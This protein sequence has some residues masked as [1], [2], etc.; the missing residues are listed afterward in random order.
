[1]QLTEIVILEIDQETIK[2][3]KLDHLQIY[4]RYLVEISIASSKEVRLCIFIDPLTE[5]QLTIKFLEENE[6]IEEVKGLELII[7]KTDWDDTDDESREEA[8]EEEDDKT[9]TQ[10]YGNKIEPLLTA[11]TG[12]ESL[13]IT[14]QNHYEGDLFEPTFSN[15]S[16]KKLYFD[17]TIIR[18]KDFP[19]ICAIFENLEE[20]ELEAE[21]FYSCNLNLTSL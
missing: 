5:P 2:E 9:D 4:S 3:D 19:S 15:V 21:N 6:F 16:C 12:L 18:Q 11:L 10:C 8:E 20:I 13:R 14:R 7:G 1:V 17:A